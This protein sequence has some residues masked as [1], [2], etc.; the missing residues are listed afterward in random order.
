MRSF[1]FKGAYHLPP[2]PHPIYSVHL[3]TICRRP[4]MVRRKNLEI[5]SLNLCNNIHEGPG[6]LCSHLLSCLDFMTRAS[7]GVVEMALLGR[8]CFKP[9]TYGWAVQ[10]E[11]W[12]TERER[13][14]QN[15]RGKT[16]LLTMESLTIFHS[17]LPVNEDFPF[18]SRARCILVWVGGFSVCLFGED[19]YLGE[20]V[21]CCALFL[22][23]WW[24]KWQ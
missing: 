10:S 22:I 9:S 7:T 2:S 3:W 21:V 16:T 15:K 14:W 8:T 20:K 23:T 1:R 19:Q 5:K 11:E 24:W 6:A 4:L 12:V 17:P 13:G 18:A